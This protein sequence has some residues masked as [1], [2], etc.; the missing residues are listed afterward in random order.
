[1]HQL[2]ILGSAI[3]FGL[4]PTLVQILLQQEFGAETIALYRFGVPFIIF[5]PSLL[6]LRHNLDEALRT[7]LIGAISAIGMVVYYA[8]F[9]LLPATTLILIYYTYPLFAIV[10]GCL[11]FAVPATRNR[12]ITAALIVVS[13]LMTLDNP[14]VSTGIKWWLWL[15]A[16]IPPLSFA[17]LLNYFSNPVKP[18]T[19]SGRMSA[20]LLGHMLVLIP[21]IVFL[22]PDKIL[23]T[24]S[25]NW[26][27]IAALGMLS[28]AIPQYLFARGSVQVGLESTT[29]IGSTEVIFAMAFSAL[30]FGEELTRTEYLA[31]I[32]MVMASLICLEPIP[33]KQGKIRSG[34]GNC[35]S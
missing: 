27:W 23:P 10:I 6:S 35:P 28:A 15:L 19:S 14:S 13:V 11:F 20:S 12:F 16:F 34:E 30:F 21:L 18:L 24:V 32:L 2:L 31:G 8:L 5:I 1:M 22:Q 29:S 17:L 9:D 3:G 7:L 25:G 33:E 26:L 4:A